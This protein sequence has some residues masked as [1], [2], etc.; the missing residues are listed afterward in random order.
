MPLLA[1]LQVGLPLTLVVWLFLWPQNNRI[2]LSLQ[3]AASAMLLLTA[4][5]VGVWTMIPVWSAYVSS[6][7]LF[8]AFLKAISRW[9]SRLMP[10]TAA[11]FS[12]SLLALAIVAATAFVQVQALSGRHLPNGQ[13]I[14]L[15]SPLKG[16][17]LRVV[18]GGSNTTI[19]AHADTLDL[20]VPRHHDW[21][22]QSYGID[23]VAQN[24]WGITSD[25]VQPADPSRYAIF[26]RPVYA[27]CSG[28]VTAERS[29]R[30]DMRVPDVDSLVM[31]GNYVTLH[32][33]GIYV[34]MAHLRYASVR[35]R[36]GDA[37][38][39]GTVI[40]HVGNS[41]MSDE[42]HLHIHAQTLPNPRSPHSGNP[43]PIVIGGRFPVRNDRL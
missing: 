43:V 29:D 31:T 10:T 18:N 12:G 38:V 42:P 23:I 26:G 15:D 35:V 21:V 19:N 8:V 37:I 1:L 2:G 40:G 6:G 39:T 7:I 3:I 25:G 28:V 20:S 36:S 14:M 27:P 32:C 17:D 16:G 22:G 11:S 30:P 13:A 4:T 33:Q 9:P 41:G 5:V 24:H 34:T